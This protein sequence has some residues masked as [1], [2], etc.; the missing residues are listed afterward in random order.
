MVDLGSWPGGWLQVASALVGPSGRVVGVDRAA[1][2][3]PLQLANVIALQADL[4]QPGV[5]EAVLEALGGLAD[6]LLCD[7]APK[8]SGVRATD[9]ANEEALL[10]AVGE[11]VPKLLKPG[12]DL[13]LKLMDGPEAEALVRRIRSLFEKVKTVR[14]EA[15]RKGTSERYLLGWRYR[16]IA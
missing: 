9:R 12:G 15:S 4:T 7:A 3:P 13:L 11:L 6:S 14:P 2:E 8:L 10:G 1:I 16:P 5:A